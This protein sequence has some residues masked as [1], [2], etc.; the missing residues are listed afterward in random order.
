MYLS[1]CVGFRYTDVRRWLSS[2]FTSTSRKRSWF[3][4][5]SSLV[6]L[7]DGFCWFRYFDAIDISSDDSEASDDEEELAEPFDP[8]SFHIIPLSSHYLTQ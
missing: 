1:V 4:L 5:S 8:S 2:L 6:N 3:S 7:M